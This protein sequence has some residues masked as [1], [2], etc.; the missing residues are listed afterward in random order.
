MNYTGGEAAPA[1]YPQT[2]QGQG[3][4][5]YVMPP[6]GGFPPPLSQAGAPGGGYGG[7]P[8]PYGYYPGMPQ[9]QPYGA[10][11][12]LPYG[13]PDQPYGAP[14]QPYGASA[15]FPPPMEAGKPTA[16]GMSPMVQPPQMVFAPGTMAT[17]PPQQQ[18]KDDGCLWALLGA[19]LC[20]CCCC[21]P[22]C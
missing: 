4:S 18:R 14:P 21:N 2:D 22:F 10:P 3:A 17:Q 16:Y 6:G 8:A 5:P 7:Q 13:A 1:G 15:G 19:T 9:Q 20:C 11:Q 12:Q